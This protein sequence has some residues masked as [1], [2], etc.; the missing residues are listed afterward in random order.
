MATSFD[1]PVLARMGRDAL[2]RLLQKMIE[3]INANETDIDTNTTAIALNTTHRT[4]DGKNH[5]DVVLNNT[6][7]AGDGSDHADVATNTSDI[8]TLDTRMDV[9]HDSN[10]YLDLASPTELTIDTD[11]AITV[12]KKYHT[13]DTFEDAATDNLDTINDSVTEGFI[14]ILRSAD[15]SRDPTLRD[16][17]DNLRLAGNF[18]LGGPNKLIM[19]MKIGSNWV[20]LSRSDN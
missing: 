15:A 12:T 13:V 5:S 6:H 20:E 10:G 19:L 18:T 2:T 1:P 4:S 17:Q 7:R 9:N 8:A 14:V 16:G 11:G 3:V